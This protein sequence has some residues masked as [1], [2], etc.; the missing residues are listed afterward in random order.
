MVD[1]PWEEGAIKVIRT[2]SCCTYLFHARN[3]WLFYFFPKSVAPYRKI[4]IKFF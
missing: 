1:K 3:S 2:S 4:T